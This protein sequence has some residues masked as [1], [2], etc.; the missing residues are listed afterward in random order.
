MPTD[1][2][3]EPNW[4]T[5]KLYMNGQELK[6]NINKTLLEQQIER[7][8][9]VKQE[10]IKMLGKTITATVEWR[11]IIPFGRR[12]RKRMMARAL[13]IMKTDPITRMLTA[14]INNELKKNRKAGGY[15]NAQDEMPVL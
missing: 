6:M 11:S 9:G 14:F 8:E 7:I 13:K 12:A 10:T 3:T 2:E 5:V 4:E 15:G 1:W